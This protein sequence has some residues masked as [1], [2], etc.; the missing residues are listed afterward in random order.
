MRIIVAYFFDGVTF[1]FQGVD[2]LRPLLEEAVKYIPKT[3]WRDTSI[4]LKATAGLRLLSNVT[5]AL[6]LEKVRM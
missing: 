6:I 5:A 2:S 3:K 4:A 1:F